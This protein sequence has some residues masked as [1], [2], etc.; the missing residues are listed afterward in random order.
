M[1]KKICVIGGGRWGQNHV[2]TLFQMNCLAAIVESNQLR[3]NELLA[4]YPN[5]QGFTNLD[6]AVAIG[7]DAYTI[8]TPAGTHYDIGKKLLM[9]GLSVLIEKPMTLCADESKE[10][11]D[12][13]QITKAKLMVGHVMLFN[14]AI[15]KIKEIIDNGKI[16]QLYYVYST[17][18]K[19]GTIRTEED[20]FWSFAPHNISVL[21]YLIGESAIKIE[22]KGEKFIQKDIYD[23]TMA[24]L[25]YPNNIHAHIMVSWLNPFKEQRLVVIG[26]K[27]MLTFDDSSKE[28]E[29]LFFN[30]RIDFVNGKPI[31]VEESDEIITYEKKMPLTEEMTYFI[32]HLDTQIDVS[33]GKSGYEVVKVLEQVQNI[34]NSK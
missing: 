15:Q 5:V 18:L 14:P 20:V 24:Q 8:A 30:K 3:L 13:A 19:L 17:L 6:D 9:K 28:K 31:I 7:F 26:S 23:M 33:G 1:I 29:I 34:L 25:E 11:L 32:E 10:L 2:K 16:G 27:G 4:L 12:I 22:A 21:N